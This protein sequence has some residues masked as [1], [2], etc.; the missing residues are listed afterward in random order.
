MGRPISKIPSGDANKMLCQRAMYRNRAGRR[1]GVLRTWAREQGLSLVSE[2]DWDIVSV[3]HNLES[4]I[5][6]L[7]CVRSAFVHE[8]KYS[9]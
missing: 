4:C 3:S 8:V 6:I 5:C 9:S 7:V 1:C 2:T